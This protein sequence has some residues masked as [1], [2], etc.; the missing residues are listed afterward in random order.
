[1]AAKTIRMTFNECE[2]SGDL[3]NYA[4][5]VRRCGGRIVEEYLN[6]E[7]E[8]GRLTVEVADAERFINRMKGTESEGFFGWEVVPARR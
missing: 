2:H 1:M 6:E 3:E 4:D 7:A 5:D 8:I